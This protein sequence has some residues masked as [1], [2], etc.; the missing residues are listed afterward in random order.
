[1]IHR[2][3]EF[4]RDKIRSIAKIYDRNRLSRIFADTIESLLSK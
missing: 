1:M 2:L 4:N 3:D